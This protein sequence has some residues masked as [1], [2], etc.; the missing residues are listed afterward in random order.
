MK[1]NTMTLMAAGTCAMIAASA[2]NAAVVAGW[3]FT[4]LSGY[5]ASPLTA[6]SSDANVTVGGLTR[7]SGIGTSGTAAGN[8][9]GGSMAAARVDAAAAITAS[10]FATFT[11]TAVNGYTVS[12]SQIDT[13]NVR[14]SG[15]GPASGQWQYAN[16][17]GSYINIGSALSFTASSSGGNTMSAVD[18]SGI[19]ALQSVAAGSAVTFRMVMYANSGTGTF[20]FQNGSGSGLSVSGTTAAIPAPG[21]V[22]LIGLAGLVA[23]R[24]RN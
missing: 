16:G 9:W 18:L 7:G 1:K 13:Y 14:R 5:G 10:Q 24:R 6:T 17:A 19:S 23:R 21:A 20:Y 11:V 2:A 22:A 8:A 3:S 4:G 15:T 12:F